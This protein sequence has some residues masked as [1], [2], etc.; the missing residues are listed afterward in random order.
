[1][2]DDA[3]ITLILRHLRRYPESDFHD[4]Y[5]LLHQAAFGPGH[6]IKD[7]RKAHEWI[8]RDLDTPAPSFNEPLVEVI[9]PAGEMVR[10]HLRP[11]AAQGGNLHRLRDAF[12]ASAEATADNPDLMARW[13]AALCEWAVAG[14]A[15]RADGFDTREMDLFGRAC[16]ERG[17]P[18][19]RHSDV[20]RSAYAPA[21]RVL[22]ADQAQALCQREKLAFEPL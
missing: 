21:Y 5:K 13:W 22:T 14:N 10:L 17:W 9:H 20:Y 8:E 11:Y 4:V 1:M 16:G 12:V 7:K 2:D 15:P 6:A 3:V 18:A 19:D